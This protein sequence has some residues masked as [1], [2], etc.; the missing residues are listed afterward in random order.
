MTHLCSLTSIEIPIQGTQS[1]PHNCKQPSH[2]LSTD[3]LFWDASTPKLESFSGDAENLL[4]I[5]VSA[6]SPR[7]KQHTHV[8]PYGGRQQKK[9]NKDTVGCPQSQHSGV[10]RLK[11][12]DGLTNWLVPFKEPHTW[13][14]AYS[15]ADKQ[16]KHPLICCLVSHLLLLEE[17]KV[18]QSIMDEV[19]EDILGFCSGAVEAQR[20]W[21]IANITPFTAF[22]SERER[23]RKLGKNMFKQAVN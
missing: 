20:Q 15:W 23:A 4:N 10:F 5:Q 19:W 6:S 3:H 1:Y 12:L 18:Q 22:S 16:Y 7:Q 2:Q 21:G 9:D 14:L 11:C 8:F 13:L 17:G